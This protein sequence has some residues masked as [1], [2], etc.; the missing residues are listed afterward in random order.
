M[1]GNPAEAINITWS[2]APHAKAQSIRRPLVRKPSELLPVTSGAVFRGKPWP[3]SPI[4]RF[5]CVSET[6]A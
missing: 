6:L 4:G 2:Q 3:T 5:Q 1:K